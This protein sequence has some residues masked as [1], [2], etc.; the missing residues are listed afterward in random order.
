M[1]SSKVIDLDAEEVKKSSRIID[2]SARFITGCISDAE[3]AEQKCSYKEI[4]RRKLRDVVGG[5]SDFSFK[6]PPRPSGSKK[7]AFYPQCD[8]QK[9]TSKTMSVS[10]LR[11][12]HIIGNALQAIFK[13]NCEL[14]RGEIVQN[15]RSNEPNPVENKNANQ[16]DLFHQVFQTVRDKLNAALNTIEE[17]CRASPNPVVYL[18][19]NMAKFGLETNIA[20]INSINAIQVNSSLPSSADP[21]IS[22][23]VNRAIPPLVDPSTSSIQ[24]VSSAASTVTPIISTS[25][26]SS[27]SVTTSS[28]S[29]SSRL[30]FSS[31]TPS[32]VFGSSPLSKTDAS[33]EKLLIKAGGNLIYQETPKSSG[34]RSARAV[35]L[36]KFQASNIAKKNRQI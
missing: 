7:I 9:G 35:L 3:V 14:C 29:S 24:D 33:A 27:Y 18:H 19:A 25:P 17:E 10:F 6:D 21:S 13:V 4:F 34:K 23:F 28:A 8:H 30:S 11:A 2:G 22:P 5:R 16:I 15:N 32:L 36:Q 26:S 20:L 31:I 1:V 12:H